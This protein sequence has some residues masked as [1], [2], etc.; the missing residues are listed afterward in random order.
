MKNTKLFL[1]KFSK[2]MAETNLNIL[3][4][5]V[6]V[7]LTFRTFQVI[8]ENGKFGFI[9]KGS[10]PAFVETLDNN[11]PADRAGIHQGDFIIK[12]NGIDVR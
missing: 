10:N 4:G 2:F 7:M 11:G 1:V 9:I 3:H 12:L 8:R 6:F 5:K